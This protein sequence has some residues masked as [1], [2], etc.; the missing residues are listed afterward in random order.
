ML[1]SQRLKDLPSAG[2][3]A[4]LAQAPLPVLGGCGLPGDPIIVAE[5]DPVRAAWVQQET[6][7]LVG[8]K[9]GVGWRLLDQQ[10]IGVGDSRAIRARVESVKVCPSQVLHELHQYDFQ[11]PLL[12]NAYSVVGLPAARAYRDPHSGLILP[13]QFSWL[14][15]K[16]VV[17]NE[18][19]QPGSGWVASYVS[20]AE[21]ADIFV[22]D[23]GAAVD[24]DEFEGERGADEFCAAVESVCEVAD[25]R[26]SEDEAVL[27]DRN[28]SMRWRVGNFELRDGRC[29]ALALTV[30]N[31][32]FVKMHLTYNALD[33][34]YAELGH[35]EIKTVL[36]TVHGGPYFVA[37]IDEE[38]TFTAGQRA[39]NH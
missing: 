35:D 3:A 29:L 14:H 15:A 9:R 10:V 8:L 34:R 20:D 28:R 27:W 12:E 2:A 39:L 21:E 36:D 26:S 5:P 6:L 30:K 32:C 31:D 22:Y 38:P 19:M 18:L 4:P 13:Y 37:K 16:E 7:R 25:C 24:Q 1:E 33:D 11:F 17:N 23:R